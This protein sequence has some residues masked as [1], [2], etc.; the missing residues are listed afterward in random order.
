MKTDIGTAIIA[1]T[2]LVSML[3]LVV[4]KISKKGGVD[5]NLTDRV[6]N[7]ETG[8]KEVSGD[9][10]TIKENHLTHIQSDIGEINVNLAEINTALKFIIKDK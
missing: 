6:H 7:L 2:S 1:V 4:N 9:I 5:K 3:I 8:F 10:K